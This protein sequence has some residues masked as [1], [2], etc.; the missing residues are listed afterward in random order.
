MGSE[1]STL[2]SASSRSFKNSKPNKPLLHEK[3]FQKTDLV[4]NLKSYEDIKIIFQK[5]D[6]DNSGSIDAKEYQEFIKDISV[7][8][9]LDKNVLSGILN[10]FDTNNDGLISFEEFIALIS[11]LNP[12]KILLLGT[13]GC[14]K[15]TL[16]KEFQIYDNVQYPLL[17]GQI[18][19][20]ISKYL[21]ELSSEINEDKTL[22]TLINELEKKKKITNFTNPSDIDHLFENKIPSLNDLLKLL[23]NIWENASIQKK[24]KEKLNNMEVPEY[25]Q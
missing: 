5:Y 16:F 8:N 15:T 12:Q 10:S 9:Q 22:A 6:T 4:N 25:F 24:Y 20:N 17:K 7:R 3:E 1:N 21:L 13:G 18:I 11:K 14:G 2:A 19:Y 23:K